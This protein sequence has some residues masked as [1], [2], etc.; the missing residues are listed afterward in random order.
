MSN[1]S[2]REVAYLALMA[3][4]EKGSFLSDFLDQWYSGSRFDPR[5]WRLAQRLAF[6]V[7]QRLKSLDYIAASLAEKGKVKMKPKEKMLLRL[8]LYQLIYMDKLPGYAVVN[9]MVKLAK[10]YTHVRFVSF[11]NA[12]LRKAEVEKISLPNGKAVKDLAIRHSYPEEFVAVLYKEYPLE[13]VEQILLLGNESAKTMVRERR[14]EIKD[15][16]SIQMSVVSPEAL[17]VGVIQDTADIEKV[18]QSSRYYIQNATPVFLIHECVKQSSLQPKKILDLCAAPGGKTILIHDYYPSA[19]LFANDITP[20][21]ITKLQDNLRRCGITAT[22]SCSPGEAY[23]KENGFDLILLDVPCSNTG[24]LNKRPEARWRYGEA[25][26]AELHSIQWKLLE[27]ARNLLAP[28]GEIWYMTCNILAEEN[29]RLVEA[30]VRKYDG[31][32]L[33]QIKQ[34]PTHTG[35]D[36]GFAARV[37]TYSS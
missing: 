2:A 32:V 3:W 37:K 21:K 26:L 5:E 6:G 25:E 11:L 29:E 34:L 27:H 33:Q 36:G 12:V 7:C 35:W 19:T 31:V 1:K 23:E 17:H 4:H 14:Q 8:G 13:T 16:Y 18:N 28:G 10:K 9:E 30:F 15:D 20:P 22:I 24:V